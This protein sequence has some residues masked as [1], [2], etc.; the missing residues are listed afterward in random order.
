MTAKHSLH[1]YRTENWLHQL[2][3]HGTALS[4]SKLVIRQ[5]VGA[6]SVCADTSAG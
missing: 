3:L 5:N 6:L 2:S 1:R 4:L